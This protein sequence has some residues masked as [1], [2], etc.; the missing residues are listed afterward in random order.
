MQAVKSILVSQVM[1]Q[2]LWPLA[3]GNTYELGCNS[4]GT[5][6]NHTQVMERITFGHGCAEN[7]NFVE[8]PQYAI[9]CGP[10]DYHSIIRRLD[11][12]VCLSRPSAGSRMAPEPGCVCNKGTY[13]RFGIK[14]SENIG[15]K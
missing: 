5:C 4:Y 8:I 3:M 13:L 2:M 11:S 7:E 14:K 15:N 9:C 10:N 12:Y 6:L 1:D